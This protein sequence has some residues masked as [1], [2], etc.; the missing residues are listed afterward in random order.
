VGRP[1]TAAS[2][3]G[4]FYLVGGSQGA[5]TPPPSPSRPF[6]AGNSD[7]TRGAD[8]VSASANASYGRDKTPLGV[9]RMRKPTAAL[10]FSGLAPVLETH[11]QGPEL[12]GH[13]SDL[14]TQGGQGPVVDNGSTLGPSAPPLPSSSRLASSE[15]ARLTFAA[16]H[17]QLRVA[18]VDRSFHEGGSVAVLLSETT[19]LQ[20]C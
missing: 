12:D 14:D 20:Q 5:V 3:Q 16:L 1:A 6:A 19:P 8:G 15:R 9:G 7:E 17:E 2:I 10:D 4:S 18:A 11:G 13:G